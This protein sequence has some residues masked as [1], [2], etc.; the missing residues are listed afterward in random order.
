MIIF[1]DAERDKCFPTAQQ[2]FSK[3]V[4]IGNTL[5]YSVVG[6]GGEEERRWVHANLFPQ[7]LLTLHLAE[8]DAADLA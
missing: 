8:F 7:F 6:W 3:V 1:L 4:L 2:Y 5:F